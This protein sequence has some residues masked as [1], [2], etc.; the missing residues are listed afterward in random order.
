M[1]RYIYIFIVCLLM[2]SCATVKL[3]NTI[4]Y[5]ET[6]SELNGEKAQVITS[7]Y[8][9]EDGLMCFNTSV[10]QDSTMIVAPCATEYGQ[11][12]YSGKLKK[13]M[14]IEI[15]AETIDQQQTLYHGII[16]PEGMVLVNQD[17]VAVGYKFISNY[18]LK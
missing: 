12:T 18:R 6:T 11:Y 3:E 16:V 10:K 4:W 2:S 5:S 17:S 14:K 13:G 1:K 9:Y 15:N 7:L 8:L